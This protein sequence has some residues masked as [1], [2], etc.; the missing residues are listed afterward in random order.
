MKNLVF[1]SKY[2]AV[3]SKTLNF[4]RNIDISNQKL[5]YTRFFTPWIWNTR[6]LERNTFNFGNLE[7]RLNSRYRGDNY[8]PSSFCLFQILSYYRQ[9]SKLKKTID[10][11][12]NYDIAIIIYVI[13]ILII[14]QIPFVILFTVW[15]IPSTV[16]GLFLC[17]WLDAIIRILLIGM[18][19]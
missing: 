3:Q 19:V 15:I 7:F 6:Y 8:V 2:L 17:V 12:S 11:Y 5:W 10:S 14:L 4:D 18:D 1:Q 16:P 13:L 9:S